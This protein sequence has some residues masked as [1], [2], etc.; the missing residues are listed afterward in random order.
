MTEYPKI[1]IVT[2]SFNQGQYI[3][4]TILSV[5]NQNY[6]NLEYIIIDGGS[7]D[8]TVEI[9]KKYEAQLKYWVSEPDKGQSDAINKGLEHCAGE[10]FNWLNSDDY[11]EP[12]ALEFIAKEYQKEPFTALCNCVNV[13]DGTVF[14]HIRNP[15]FLG[16]DKEESIAKFNINQEGTWFSLNAV[17]K[18][19]GVNESLHLL[20]DL[21]LWFKL[22]CN[23]PFISFRKTDYIVSNFRR[24]ENAKSTIG[25]QEQSNDGGFLGEQVN[26]FQLFVPN[27]SEIKY[28][29]YFNCAPNS[30][31]DSRFF[32]IED[33]SKIKI[34]QLYLYE[35]VKLYFYEN[36]FSLAKKLIK[37]IDTN[38]LPQYKKDIQYLKR[39]LF[40]K[41]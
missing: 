27:N 16:A 15:S 37:L 25:N 2:P 17:K 20:M 26:L 4:Q 39:K 22:L 23:F 30:K 21:E 41:F 14:S 38:T 24:H 12:G 11:L 40:F 33:K 35:K 10:I 3:E 32:Q 28:S 13:I 5:L 19:I 29:F 8:N 9:I 34:T 6:P 1:S 18:M 31:I 36:Q 7:S